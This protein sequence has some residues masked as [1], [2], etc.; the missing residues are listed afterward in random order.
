MKLPGFVDLQVNGY[1]GVDFSDP[2]LDAASAVRA[3]REML[4]AGTAAFLPTLVTS[5][6]QTY[7]R[8]LGILAGVLEQEEFRGRLPGIHLEG[9]FLSREEG[10]RGA[11]HPEWMAAPDVDLLKRLLVWAQGKVRM[12]TIAAE[13]EG[14]DALA[15]HAVGEGVTVALGHHLARREDLERLREAGAK[16]LTHLGNGVPATLP[17]HDNP[18]WAGLAND[19]LDATIV[20]DGHHLPAD[21]I[22]SFIRTKGVSRLAVVSDASPVAGMPPG[23]YRALGNDV[24]L[25]ADG[26]LSNPATGYLVG[27]SATML[28]CMNHLASLRLLPPEDL[29]RMGVDNP[30][31]L[32]G[33][34][35][36]ALATGD[37]VEYVQ[38]ENRFRLVGTDG[39]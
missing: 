14:A 26:R 5:P 10:A 9:P 37:R 28:H 39:Q 24:V 15:A 36:R 16:V 17:R 3:C 25:E 32:I 18:I 6:P 22:R 13:L 7:E 30:L 31:S 12:I 20:T 11:H 35:R 21:L 33:L 2:A 19:G 29:I 1:A 38:A 27:S 8:N 34:D 4:A 23:R